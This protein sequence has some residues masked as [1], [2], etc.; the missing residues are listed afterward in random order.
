MQLHTDLICAVLTQAA[1]LKFQL[2]SMAHAKAA[3]PTK[4]I[5]NSRLGLSILSALCPAI[6]GRI[7]YGRSPNFQ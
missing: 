5:W 1:C 2:P 7:D 4:S 6:A 3:N